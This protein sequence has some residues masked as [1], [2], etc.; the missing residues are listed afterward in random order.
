MKKLAQLITVFTIATAAIFVLSLQVF[1]QEITSVADTTIGSTADQKAPFNVDLGYSHR[2][3]T[4]IK[5]SGEDFNV[6]SV[7][8]K[9][10]NHFQLN[11]C[12]TLNTAINYEYN[13]YQFQN[14]NRYQWKNRFDWNRVHLV[15]INSMLG[16]TLDD[17]WS[18]Y[19][20]PILNVGAEEGSEFKDT[21]SGG[22]AAGFNY[23]Y[24]PALTLGAGLAVVSRIEDPA[25]TVPIVRLDWKFA[26]KWNLHAGST[27]LGS[28]A[29][30][31]MAVSFAP[32]ERLTLSSGVQEQ[33]KRFRLANDWSPGH[34]K[35]GVATD[36]YSV[37]Y[38]KACYDITKQI[39]IEGYAG[40]AFSG[41]L[42]L[43]DK[44]G[45]A[46]RE[47]EYDQTPMFGLRTIF[48]F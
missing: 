41:K 32:V 29:G 16:Y 40:M 21:L 12:Y 37:A 23:V 2:I 4:D 20:G 25:A 38:A 43:E 1:A 30:Y 45:Q 19:G 18:F 28:S 46:I 35:D 3:K 9:A 36:K 39:G 22:A 48:A 6:Q 31:G 13:D 47:Q 8:V 34:P 42:K 10:S 14:T 33:D 26:D 27:E 24:S 17:T 7:G 11:P 5:G 15:T 44:S